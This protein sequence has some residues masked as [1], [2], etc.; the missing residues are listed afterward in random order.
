MLMNHSKIPMS[1][2]KLFLALDSPIQGCLQITP[3][4]CQEQADYKFAECYKSKN[5]DKEFRIGNTISMSS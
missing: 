3:E 4:Y 5:I 1:F 2:T